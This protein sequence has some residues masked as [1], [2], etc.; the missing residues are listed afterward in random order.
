MSRGS[1]RTA[2]VVLSCSVVSALLLCLT[3]VSSRTNPRYL[4]FLPAGDSQSLSAGEEQEITL[5]VRNRGTEPLRV[6]G[7]SP[8]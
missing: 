8:G 1:L 4:V 2:T 6:I 5:S 3:L 7:F